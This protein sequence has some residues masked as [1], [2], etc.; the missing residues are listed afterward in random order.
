MTAILVSLG[1]GVM[2]TLTVQLLQNSLLDQLRLS[3]PPDSPNVFLINVTASDKDA[4]WKLI[5]GQKGIV[6]VPEANPAVAGQLTKING[7]PVEQIQLSEDEQRYFR[8]QFALTWSEAIPKATEIL[9]GS[10][11][12]HDTRDSLVSVEE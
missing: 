9:S 4:L 5:R 11:W 1:V 2:F 10:W 8:T 12:P 6:D 3:S 7:T